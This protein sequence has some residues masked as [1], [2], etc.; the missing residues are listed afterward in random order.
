MARF[1]PFWTALKRYTSSTMLDDDV[2]DMEYGT[3]PCSSSIHDRLHQYSLPLSSYALFAY[4]L[5][6]Y[7]LLITRAV[8]ALCACVCVPCVCHMSVC[9]GVS[10]VRVCVCV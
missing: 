7:R 5:C 3:M 8:T 1:L 2:I 9:M 4:C 10:H 6:L